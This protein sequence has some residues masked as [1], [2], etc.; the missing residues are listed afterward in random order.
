MYLVIFNLFFSILINDHAFCKP[1][2]KSILEKIN[3][4]NHYIRIYK[5]VEIN[6]CQKIINYLKIFNYNYDNLQICT[7][8][9]FNGIPFD[10]FS[11][12][13]HYHLLIPKIDEFGDYYVTIQMSKNNNFCDTILSDKTVEGL[14]KKQFV[15][16]NFNF[17]NCY[18]LT[19]INLNKQLINKYL[20]SNYCNVDNHIK[21]VIR[22]Y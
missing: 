1:N 11:P 3:I 5:N 18:D 14:Y 2:H 7:F 13:S 4:G 9:D 10:K 20:E 16:N 19:K 8:R 12:L 21:G 6:S 17:Y 15:F 22:R